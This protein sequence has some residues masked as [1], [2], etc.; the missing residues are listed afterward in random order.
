MEWM[1]ELVSQKDW[2]LLGLA[3]LVAG[4]GALSKLLVGHRPRKRGAL[5]V[6]VSAFWG[7]L[8]VWVM[9]EW[10]KVPTTVLMALSAALGWVGYEAT[11]AWMLGWLEEKAG[12][13]G[14]NSGETGNTKK[15][16]KE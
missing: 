16:A 8:G 10:L 11:T 6:L 3:T 5:R 1:S 15:E 9:A 12:A 4:L 14:L 2:Q 7:G 13:K